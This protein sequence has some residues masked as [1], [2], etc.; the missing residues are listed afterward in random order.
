MRGLI[1]VLVFQQGLWE[2]CGLKRGSIILGGF[3]TTAMIR[4]S[5]ELKLSVMVLLVA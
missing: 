5:V 3:I 1:I 4:K 2:F